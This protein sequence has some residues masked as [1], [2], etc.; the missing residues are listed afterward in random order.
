MHMIDNADSYSVVRSKAISHIGISH[1][2]S[3]RVRDYLYR[4]GVDHSLA[5]EVVDT[6]IVDGYIDDLRVARSIASGRKGKKSESTARLRQRL[7]AFG[8]SDQAISDLM[9]E[10]PTD[11][12]TIEHLVNDKF[13]DTDFDKLNHEELDLWTLSAMRFLNSRGFSRNL[14]LFA[15][16]KFITNDKAN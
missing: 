16:R 9:E 3:G 7:L 8:V 12:I 14:S 10:L 11:A 1:K 13:Q 2:S 15:I 6:L 4:S 5:D